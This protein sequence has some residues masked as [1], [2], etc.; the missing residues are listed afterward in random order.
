[1][2]LE[3]YNYVRVGCFEAAL[4]SA[5]TFMDYFAARELGRFSDLDRRRNERR[6]STL[7]HGLVLLAKLHRIFGS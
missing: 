5:L 3:A 6:C 1:M 7:K 2:L 4:E